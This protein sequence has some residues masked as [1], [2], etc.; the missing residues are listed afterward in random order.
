MS[1][2]NQFLVNLFFEV[3]GLGLLFY[4]ASRTLDFVQMTMPADK[5]FMGYL[6]LLSTGIGSLIWMAVYLK[7]ARGAAQRGIAFGMGILDL[8]GE[9][10]MVYADTQYVSSQSGKV[11]MSQEELF[12]LASVGIMGINAIAYY[13]FKMADPDATADQKVQDLVDDAQEATYKQLNSPEARAEMI[14]KHMPALQ[15]AIMAKVQD[16]VTDM[17]GRRTTEVVS[18]KMVPALTVND[19]LNVQDNGYPMPEKADVN[20]SD[21]VLDILQRGARR[22][23]AQ[24]G[25]KP[26][27]EKSTTTQTPPP[28]PTYHPMSKL[29]PTNEEPVTGWD[30]ASERNAGLGEYH[31]DPK[32]S[33]SPMSQMMAAV[34]DG[35]V[36][37]LD[38]WHWGHVEKIGAEF[39]TVDDE[40]RF[41]GRVRSDGQLDVI[42]R[43]EEKPATAADFRNPQ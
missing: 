6:Y 27:A 42:E 36:M 39:T 4:A 35:Y 18:R 38:P 43:L 33:A 41:V 5:Q 10:V 16:S 28:L 11:V 30:H 9:F 31:P 20:N 3:L 17:V 1:R 22:V 19:D 34:P 2:K 15:A 40:G 12:I 24:V 13:S 25:L 8:L 32:S 7:K 26:R 14:A 21:S 37:M 23:A 29:Q